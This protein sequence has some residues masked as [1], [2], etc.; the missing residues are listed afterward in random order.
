M[1]KW[2]AVEDG[3]GYLD[4]ALVIE[5]VAGGDSIAVGDNLVDIYAPANVTFKSYDIGMDSASVYVGEGGEC[6]GE[7]LCTGTDGH[8]GDVYEAHEG[9]K[10]RGIA[11]AG[12]VDSMFATPEGLW[13]MLVTNFHAV[14]DSR[15]RISDLR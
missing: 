14:E 7:T 6:Y 13:E 12:P 1:E 9:R 11:L 15:C 5:P 2:E 3:F 8:F 10:W 4:F